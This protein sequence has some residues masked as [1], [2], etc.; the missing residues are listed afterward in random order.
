MTLPVKKKSE[1]TELEAKFL[2]AL[3][4]EAQGDPGKAKKLAGYS[5][6]TSTTSIVKQLRN[7]INDIAMN[8]LAMGAP[9]AALSLVNLLENPTTKSADIILKA[10]AQILDRTGVIKKPEEATIKIGTQ[11]GLFIL[12]AK[13]KFN[14][15]V[16]TITL[17]KD[18]YNDGD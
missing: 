2:E 6:T 10:A 1:L 16:P 12:P 4:G 8:Q 5:D 15:D 17:D 7:E 9:K 11:G 14:D 13:G 18:E 3:F